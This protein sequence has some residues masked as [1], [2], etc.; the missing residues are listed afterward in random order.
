MAGTQN[1]RHLRSGFQYLLTQGIAIHPGHGHICDDQ[2]ESFRVFPEQGQSLH[3]VRASGHGIAQP[4]QAL[5]IDIDNH[6]FVVH[7]QDL[8]GTPGQV[9]CDHRFFRLRRF[10]SRREIDFNRRPLSD[11]TADP[12]AA[13]MVFDYA[14]DNRE[15]QS[16]AFAHLLCREVGIEDP[17]TI[18]LGNPVP[19]I[20]NPQLD[21]ASGR[22]VRIKG[23][24]LL[25][26]G[27]LFKPHCEHPSCFHG[28]RGIGAEIDQDL[29][30]LG[31][32]CFHRR[33][34]GRDEA[35][36][37]DTR[38]DGGPEHLQALFDHRPDVQC[39]L[40]LFAAPGE[41][42][43]LT[44]DVPGPQRSGF[45]FVQ[46]LPDWTGI[47]KLHLGDFCIPQNDS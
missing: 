15:S 30:D 24:I 5:L 44:D 31:A 1:D 41:G 38:G 2:I 45:H 18:I 28:V 33:Q 36:E 35:L 39:L 8:L 43:E 17:F 40:L 26:Q 46:R 4:F 16:R 12:D 13:F 7:E 20:G 27:N 14:Q 42:Q 6:D 34:G 11:L 21:I 37:L 19:C 10:R 3:R 29:V 9:R 23:K 25:L 32:I 22:Q 47:R